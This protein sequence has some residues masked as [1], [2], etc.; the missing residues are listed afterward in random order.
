MGTSTAPVL[1]EI[2]QNDLPGGR[3]IIRLSWSNDRYHAVAVQGECTADN[4]A[5]ALHSLACLVQNDGH[6][7][8]TSHERMAE[9]TM[10]LPLPA[11]KDGKP[12]SH[13]GCL[14]HV[15]H[16]CEGCGRIVGK[17]S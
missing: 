13:T 15:T 16:S 3:R 6:L 14:N 17:K 5:E 7:R 2:W 8:T 4:V 10:T 1:E 12:C 9:I 11:H